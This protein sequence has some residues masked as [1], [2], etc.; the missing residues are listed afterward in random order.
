MIK[1]ILFD[2]GG[3]LYNID[4]AKTITAFEQRGF[5]SFENMFSQHKANAFFQNLETGKIT[6]DEF[7]KTIQAVA[8]KATTTEQIQ[9]AWNALLLGYR[10]ESLRFL[11]TLKQHYNLFLLS[12]T[13]QIHY[14]YFTHQLQQKTPY[15]SLD[16]FFTKAYYSHKIGLRKPD[17]AVFEYVTNDAGILANETLFI[18]DTHSNFPNAEKLGM[19][20]HL[21]LSDETIETLQYNNY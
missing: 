9:N 12:N 17:T 21:L 5:S 8:P 13:N 20:T 6:P 15:N 18:D 3:V 11:I 1:N 14:D 4:F 2:F 16:S 19:K 7:Y 10:T